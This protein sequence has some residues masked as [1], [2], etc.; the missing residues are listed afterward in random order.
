[1]AHRKLFLLIETTIVMTTEILLREFNT[2]PANLQAQVLEFIQF[3]K[4][5][6]RSTKPNAT[7]SPQ[8]PKAGF[9][10]YKIVMRADFDAPLEEFKAYI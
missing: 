3:L 7:P 1:L 6:S 10:K 5:A 4:S 2:L 9:G 8:A